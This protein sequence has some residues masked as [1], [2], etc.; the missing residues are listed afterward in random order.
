VVPDLRGFNV[1]SEISRVINSEV[2][3]TIYP[4]IILIRLLA[5]KLRVIPLIA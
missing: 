2:G 5:I 3:L 4:Y 1:F